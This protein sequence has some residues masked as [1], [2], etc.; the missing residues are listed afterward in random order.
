MYH[1][2]TFFAGPKTPRPPGERGTRETRDPQSASYFPKAQVKTTGLIQPV[3]GEFVLRFSKAFG[4]IR[5]HTLG[6][7]VMK[8]NI[9]VVEFR[10]ILPL[11]T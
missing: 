5:G 1:W 8:E 9:I 3:I 2:Q 6:W 10:T 11:S 7:F 4:V